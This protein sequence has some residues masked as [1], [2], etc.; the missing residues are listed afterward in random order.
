MAPA[1]ALG[2][3]HHQVDEGQTEAP[4][5]DRLAGLQRGQVAVGG[6]VG[7]QVDESVLA[8]VCGQLGLPE[9]GVGVE[10]A[11]GEHDQVGE[12][13]PRAALQPHLPSPTC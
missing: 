10:V 2:E 4:Y 9:A 13:R 11:E 3:Q 7:R 6:E 1:P 8:G 12:E 5:E